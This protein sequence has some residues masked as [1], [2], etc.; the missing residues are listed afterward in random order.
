MVTAEAL[1]RAGKKM[2][3]G[4]LPSQVNGNSTNF[5]LYHLLDIRN[6]ALTSLLLSNVP[7]E[8]VPY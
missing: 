2:Q 7:Q 6:I 3:D 4:A 1:K 8:L 5:F